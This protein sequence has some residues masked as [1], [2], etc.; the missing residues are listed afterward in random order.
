MI[1]SNATF[2]PEM[3]EDGVNG[4]LLPVGENGEDDQ[5]I[6][7]I[8]RLSTDPALRARLGAAAAERGRAYHLDQVAPRYMALFEQAIETGR[9]RRAGG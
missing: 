7:A 8:E 5:W 3:I 9:R 6:A 2:A 1:A 4:V